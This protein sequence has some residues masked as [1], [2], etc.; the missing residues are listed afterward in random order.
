VDAEPHL[1]PGSEAGCEVFRAGL[2]YLRYRQ[3]VWLLTQ[4]GTLA[5]LVAVMLFLQ[6]ITAMTV[7]PKLQKLASAFTPG[8]WLG[9]EA[10]GF[11]AFLVQL[12][13]SWLAIRW[14]W[15]CRWY[16]LSDR[17][18]RVQEGILAFREQTFTLANIQDVSVR[19]NP[20][21][22]LFGL[23]D[24]EVRTAGGGEASPGEELEGH[25]A[26]L[27]TARLRGV[28][29]GARIRDRLLEK[30]AASRDAGLGEASEASPSPAGLAEAL[31]RARG[32]AAAL[33]EALG[34]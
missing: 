22:R 25:G 8:L 3:L 12:P 17:C 31:R 2:A 28:E 30:M 19:Q 26:S 11:A 15:D 13:F 16:L 18:L 5:G 10:A 20:L 32:E 9:L 4:L 27:H 1:P 14:D 24:V 34:R 29:H 23:W 21:Q 33:R 7:P 6:G